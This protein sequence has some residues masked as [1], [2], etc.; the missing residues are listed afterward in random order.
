M[1]TREELIQQAQLND[2]WVLRLTRHELDAALMG[3][4]YDHPAGHLILPDSVALQNMRHARMQVLDDMAPIDEADVPK[5]AR[6]EL[7]EKV[8]QG[9]ND[10]LEG[11]NAWYSSDRRYEMRESADRS[12][13]QWF[14]RRFYGSAG[15]VHADGYRGHSSAPTAVTLE[16]VRAVAERLSISGLVKTL[17]DIG[18]TARLKPQPFAQMGSPWVEHSDA[19]AKR[20]V[21]EG[22]VPEDISKAQLAK[23][24]RQEMSVIFSK[25]R[26]PGVAKR[27]GSKLP[28]ESTIERSGLPGFGTYKRTR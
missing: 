19:I 9:C 6:R 28:T 16:V 4:L 14:G 27:G 2:G 18:I 15:R 7:R 11:S 22:T 12:T 13:R 8:T 10:E 20:L 1:G 17:D 3:I 5:A 24:V 21:A 25:T 23:K 26:S